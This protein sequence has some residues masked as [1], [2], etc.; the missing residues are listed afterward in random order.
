[1]LDGSSDRSKPE[2]QV[3][4]LNWHN[5]AVND[6]AHHVFHGV[7]DATPG[8]KERV[9]PLHEGRIVTFAASRIFDR[10]RLRSLP[11]GTI[12]VVDDGLGVYPP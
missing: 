9:R 1:M 8:K 5:L 7:D 2:V 12:S 3:C 11:S 6:P 10:M 4:W